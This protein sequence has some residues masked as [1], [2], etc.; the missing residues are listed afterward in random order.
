MET[1]DVLI[2]ET[3][4]STYSDLCP[5]FNP[6]L[7]PTINPQPNLIGQFALSIVGDS[8][9]FIN[10]ALVDRGK[11]INTGFFAAHSS[12]VRLCIIRSCR[13]DPMCQVVAIR[14]TSDSR[15]PLWRVGMRNNYQT[16]CLNK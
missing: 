6:N 2:A 11:V 13:T 12:E 3:H 7:D 4:T 9:G 1:A 10:F 5:S 16:D 14:F 8:Y 15:R